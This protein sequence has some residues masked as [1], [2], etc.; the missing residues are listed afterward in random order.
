MYMSSVSLRSLRPVRAPRVVLVGLLVTLLKLPC[1]RGFPCRIPAPASETHTISP[2]TFRLDFSIVLHSADK[3]IMS[4]PVDPL[5]SLAASLNTSEPQLGTMPTPDAK[6]TGDQNVQTSPS[7][8]PPPPTQISRPTAEEATSFLTSL[9]DRPLRV[10]L[11]D[12]RTVIG[13]LYVIDGGGN[14]ILS[15]AE[16]FPANLIDLFDVNRDQNKAGLNA[17]EE[18]ELYWRSERVR[19]EINERWE[20]GEKWLPKSEPFGGP[21]TGWGGR[22]LG[23]V[24]AKMEDC[25]RIELLDEED[26]REG[27][28]VEILAGEGMT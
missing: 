18:E 21:G 7:S 11:K 26:G 13:R 24:L 14:M 22:G 10:T 17:D 2:P 23:L 12:D 3:S 1:Y 15:E 4:E 16:E 9:L 19:A 6:S 5:L 28:G 20:K 8:A 27:M 25:T